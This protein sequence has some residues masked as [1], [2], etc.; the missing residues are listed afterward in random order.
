MAEYDYAVWHVL[1][2]THRMTLDNSLTT[3]CLGSPGRYILITC[4]I[5]RSLWLASVYGELKWLSGGTLSHGG[6]LSRATAS[7]N[8]KKNIGVS[9]QSPDSTLYRK[10]GYSFFL[11]FHGFIS[12]LLTRLSDVY[13]QE[14]TVQTIKQLNKY[15]LESCGCFQIQARVQSN[16]NPWHPNSHIFSSLVWIIDHMK[17]SFDSRHITVL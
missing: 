2:T 15:A 6:L 13:E 9:K 10:T 8:C 7:N 17:Q 14:N 16:R 5:H 12:V 11:S 4:D 3:V 1:P